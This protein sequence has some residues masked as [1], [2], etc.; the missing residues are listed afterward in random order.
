MG[1]TIAL[2]QPVFQTLLAK[3]GRLRQTSICLNITSYAM[4]ITGFLN[5]LK[6][7]DINAHIM[8]AIV[9]DAEP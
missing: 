2:G 4:L 8:T 6:V 9:V 7:K 3:L 5:I 1:N